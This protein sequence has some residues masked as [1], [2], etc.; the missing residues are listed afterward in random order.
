MELF[1]KVIRALLCRRFIVISL[2]IRP[3]VHQ[4]ICLS[5]ISCLELI[6][7]SL[8]HS[9]SNFIYRVSLS[10]GYAVTLNEFLGKESRSHWITQFFIGAYILSSKLVLLLLHINRTF[11]KR[12]YSDLEP[13]YKVKCEDHCRIILKSLVQGIFLLP[14]VTILTC[15]VILTKSLSL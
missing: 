12:V 10:K 5:K 9:A 14:L 7:S 1:T 3:S 4:T 6:F 2:S 15:V 13:T 8:A 11:G